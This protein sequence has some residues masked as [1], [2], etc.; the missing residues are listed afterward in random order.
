V[1]RVVKVLFG[2]LGGVFYGAIM[3]VEVPDGV[4][5]KAAAILKMF[6]LS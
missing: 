4:I 1:A 5:G 6:F 3:I 2:F